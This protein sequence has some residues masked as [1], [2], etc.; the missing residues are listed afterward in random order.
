MVQRHGRHEQT[1][2]RLSHIY[3]P[4]LG[5]KLY[6]RIT[7]FILL[8]ET[9]SWHVAKTGLILCSSGWIWV[10]D[11]PAS[12]LMDG[13]I[14]MHHHVWTGITSYVTWMFIGPLL[15]KFHRM[16]I[17]K[18]LWV[19]QRKWIEGRWVWKVYLGEWREDIQE[20][21]GLWGRREGTRLL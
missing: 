12:A 20:A 19:H 13:T 9:G 2:R 7:S 8:F 15:L 10:F 3:H 6:R 5:C 11:S 1:M 17:C 16:N 18:N 21:R 14:G 4:P